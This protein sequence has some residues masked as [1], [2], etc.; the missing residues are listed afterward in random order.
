MYVSAQKADSQQRSFFRFTE[1]N[2]STTNVTKLEFKPVDSPVPEEANAKS[3]DLAKQ[4]KC[5]INKIKSRRGR[6][7]KFK[8][9]GLLKFSILGNYSNGLKAKLKSLKVAVS[10]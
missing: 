2:F 4:K 9:R 6:G 1:H 8:G 10:I 3:V 5:S 7:K